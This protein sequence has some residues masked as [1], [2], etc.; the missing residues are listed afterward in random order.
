MAKASKF[1]MALIDEYRGQMLICEE[2][3]ED[4]VLGDD[5]DIRYRKEINSQGNL[6]VTITGICKNQEACKQRIG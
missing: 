3:K 4:G 2:C 1:Q 6:I 5:L